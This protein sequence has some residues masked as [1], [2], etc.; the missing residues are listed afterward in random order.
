MIFSNPSTYVTN[1]KT[2]QELRQS[3]SNSKKITR[4]QI[5]AYNSLED[6]DLATYVTNGLFRRGINVNANNDDVERVHGREQ[7]LAFLG[8]RGGGNFKNAHV[9]DLI[10]EYDNSPQRQFSKSLDRLNARIAQSDQEEQERWQNTNGFDAFGRPALPQ[11][12]A[13]QQ[14]S[15]Q[16]RWVGQRPVA[17]PVMTSSYRTD[18]GST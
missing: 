12:T 18:Y 7:S 6:Y 4:Q 1:A 13:E 17:Q 2:I 14:D 3:L 15:L 5:G 11:L 8:A 10:N 16:R 9:N